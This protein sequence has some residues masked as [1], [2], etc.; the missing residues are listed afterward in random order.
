MTTTLKVA[1]GRLKREIFASVEF[2]DILHRIILAFPEVAKDNMFSIKLW[3]FKQSILAK[4]G[5]PPMDCQ[6]DHCEPEETF[7]CESCLKERAYCFGQDDDFFEL[8]DDC[9]YEQ[10]GGGKESKP[11]AGESD[12][13]SMEPTLATNAPLSL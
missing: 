4:I 11:T 6:C 13:S 12:D 9:W 1:L 3:N 5:K 10:E 8:C 7:A 2:P